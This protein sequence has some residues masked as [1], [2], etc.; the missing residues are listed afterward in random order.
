MSKRRERGF[1]LVELLIVVVVIGIVASLAIPGVQKA[2]RAAESGNVY[3]TMRSISS[4]QIGFFS[5][6]NRFARLT[7][8]NNLLSGA[9]GTPSGTDVIHGKFVFSMVPAAPS[10]AELT[11]GYTITAIRNV[12]G[13]DIIYHYTLTQSGEIV[14]ILP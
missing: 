2:L 3:A 12:T 10:Q 5:Q 13:E 4:T 8:V 7:E 1:S 6:N 14:Q 11:E 9:V